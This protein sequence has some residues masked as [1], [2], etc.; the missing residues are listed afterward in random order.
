MNKNKIKFYKKVNR[1][2]PNKLFLIL[3]YTMRFKRLPNIINPKRYTEK[4]QLRMINDNMMKYTD[5][6]DKYKVRDFIKE[7]I[8]EKYLIDLIGVY[9]DVNEI[10]FNKLPE[11]FVIKS[12][13][14][15]GYFLICKDKSKLDIEESKEKINNWIKENYYN[16]CK[17]KQ[18]KNI[19]RKIICEK[20][21]EDIDDNFLDCRVYCFNGKAEFIQVD[22]GFSDGKT[23]RN[24]YDI[25]WNEL[26]LKMKYNK[27]ENE[28]KKPKK[29]KEILYLAEILS[30]S[31]D[32]VRVDFYLSDE[33]IY[34]SELTF[35]PAGGRQ[36]LEPDKYDFEFGKKLSV[37]K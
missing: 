3:N 31:F 21:I 25:N 10:N 13:H 11:K 30:A 6:V 32:F 19:K 35:S 27:I 36:A 28:V 12:N 8:G 37:F 7:K 5:Y 34:F 14:G 29:L 15:S 26:D 9:D 2:I 33:K 18:Y 4:I 23:R 17:E 16:K 22:K 1:F 20:L 24:H